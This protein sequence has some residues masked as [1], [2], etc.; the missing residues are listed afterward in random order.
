MREVRIDRAKLQAI[1]Q[2]NRSEH[3]DIFLKAQAKYRELIIQEL[4]AVLAMAR[5]NKDIPIIRLVEIVAPS[6]HTHD[7]DRALRMLEL[8][9]DSIITLTAQEFASLVDDD[10]GWSRE[11]AA[12]NVRYTSSSKFDKYLN[13][14]R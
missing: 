2:K 4:D 14:S 9:T 3:R 5:D 6:D 1:I 12:S 10:W 8:S 11:W 13:N 7:Y